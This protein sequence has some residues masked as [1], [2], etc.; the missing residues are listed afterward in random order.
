MSEDNIINQDTNN[1]SMNEV[2]TTKNDENISKVSEMSSNESIN[3]TMINNASINNTSINNTTTSN[4]TMAS[5]NTMVSN[6]TMAGSVTVNEV[7]TA[8]NETI[9]TAN[10][11]T[12]NESTNTNNGLNYDFW[13]D[14]ARQSDIEKLNNQNMPVTLADDMLYP[15]KTN[16]KDKKKFEMKPLY[17]GIGVAV[18]VLLVG[19]SVVLVAKS[20]GLDLLGNLTAKKVE[21]T[22]LVDG[23]YEVAS[24]VSDIV[25]QSMPSVVAITETVNIKGNGFYGDDT[26]QATGN[27]SGIIIAENENELYI[28]TNNHVVAD[29]EKLEVKFIDDSTVKATAKGTNPTEDLAVIYVK[30][31]DIKKETLAKIKIAST[32]NSD[33]VKVGDRAIAI[34]NAL[35]QGQTVT[36]GFISAT[37]REINVENGKMKVMQTDAAINPGNSG[38]A[39]LNVKG[40]VIGIN[41]AKLAATEV[42]GMG[43][44]IPISSAK[45]Y[46]QKII[47]SVT[48][49]DDEKG[50]LGVVAIGISE[51]QSKEY[52]WPKGIYVSQLY[53]NGAAKKAGIKE[54]DIITKI[55]DEEIVDVKVFQEKLATYKKGST[56]KI[57]LKRMEDGK[58][59]EKTIDVQLTGVLDDKD[60]SKN[61]SKDTDTSGQR[62]DN[63]NDNEVKKVPNTLP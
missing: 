22:E 59:K 35:G 6:N 37:N 50:F 25:E 1:G 23:D 8:T 32:A 51:Q 11:A 19:I 26:R 46:L 41:S 36:A 60:L 27:G 12:S 39:L 31:S 16:K 17:I 34:G 43:Y 21:K 38:G 30:K 56:V 9:D 61:N 14:T 53:N 54:R 58:Y 44:A 24:D 63:N 40:E 55:D 45:S 3:N 57:T 10:Q 29:A 42:E 18:I 47:D 62:N 33:E 7:V 4:N 5:N 2:S 13:S 49:N 48:Y 28:A 15:N 20:R 52:G